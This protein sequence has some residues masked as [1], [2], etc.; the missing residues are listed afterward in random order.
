MLETLQA[1]KA[2]TPKHV[3]F[4]FERSEVEG[5][6]VEDDEKSERLSDTRNL[7]TFTMFL[8]WVRDIIKLPS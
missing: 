6:D 8:N 2:V 4:C 1:N 7:K 3:C 5:E